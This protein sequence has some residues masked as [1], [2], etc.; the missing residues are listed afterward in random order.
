M[1]LFTALEAAAGVQICAK[2]CHGA[3]LPQVSQHHFVQRFVRGTHITDIHII[4]H[5]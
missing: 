1:N 4:T 2:S 5:V 3:G